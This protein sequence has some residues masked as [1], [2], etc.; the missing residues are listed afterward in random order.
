MRSCD[1]NLFVAGPEDN[2]RCFLCGGGLKSWKPTDDP[3]AE[4]QRWFPDCPFM[5]GNKRHGKHT[6]DVIAQSIRLNHSFLH[7]FT[8]KTRQE[9]NAEAVWARQ[10]SQQ[11]L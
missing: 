1:S 10:L 3:C 2:V 4:H 6:A 7:Y 9:C 5:S 8:A 11:L